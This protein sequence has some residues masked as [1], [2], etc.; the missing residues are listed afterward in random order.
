MR[1]EAIALLALSCMLIVGCRAMERLTFI[2]PSAKRGE[3]T[4]V[5][6]TY[7]VS[8][9]NQKQR[10]GAGDATLL[11]VSATTLYQRG[12][13]QQS[14]RQARRALELAPRS[15]DAHTLLGL[16]ADARGD[17]KTAGAH[18][19]QAVE[20]MP[21]KGVY[22]NNYGGWLCANGQPQESLAW[23][24]RALA[25]GSYASPASALVNA[26]SCARK[27]G[28]PE[29]A[30]AGWRAALG[31]D[32]KNL[33]ALSGMAHLQ[34]DSGRAL[35]ARAFV[36]RW[37]ELA[38]SDRD[39]LQLAVGIEQK[40]GDNVAASRYLSRLQALPPASTTVPRTQ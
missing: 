9:K 22:A 14:E 17:A 35:E 13:L 24:D 2:R 37:L 27:A 39:A 11:L 4:Q 33:L 20:V 36:E 31:I 28:L 15:A 18:Y 10:Q 40:L 16:I 8:G 1:R 19:R 5:A 38:P 23:F 6:P 3:Y 26:G 21:D 29:R 7:D 34:Y 12:E 25:D 32:P 30:E